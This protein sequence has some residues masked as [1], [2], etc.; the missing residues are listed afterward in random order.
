MRAIPSP[1]ESTRPVSL[2]V[3]EP[4]KP[5]I[6]LRRISLISDGLISAMAVDFLAA[7]AGQPALGLAEARSQAAVVDFSL[8]LGHDAAEQRFVHLHG[9]DYGLAHHHLESAHHRL[10]VPRPRPARDSPRG[11]RAPEQHVKLLL[12]RL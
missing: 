4:S 7:S 6:S 2:T 8:Q 11:P 5:L 3:I 10:A 1:H 9:R 12:V